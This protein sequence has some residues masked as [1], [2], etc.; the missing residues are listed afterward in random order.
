MKDNQ[1]QSED[2]PEATVSDGP[3]VI[4]TLRSNASR[5]WILTAICLV[6]AVVLFA[7]A[8]RH[9]GTEITVRF[10]QGYGI[11]AGDMLRH[12][13]I[14]VGEVTAVKLDPELGKINVQILL[15]TA[16]EGL[17]RE[18]SRFWVERPR[19]SLARVSGLETVVGA[20]YLGVLPG[21]A[22][23]PKYLFDGDESPLMM[24]DSDVVEITLLFREGYGLQVGDELRHRGIVVG[25]VSAVELNDELSGVEVTVRLIESAQRLARAGSQFWIE[26]PDVSLTRIRGLDTLVGG[27]Y[28]AVAP[29]PSEAE[30]LTKFAGLDEPPMTGEQMEGGLEIALEGRH[31]RGVRAGAPVLY[32]GHRIGQVI[33][34]GLSPDASR[35]E[36]RAYIDPTFKRLVRDNT[37]FW[38]TSGIKANLS[39]SGGL[40]VTA[41]TLETIAAGGVTLATPDSPGKMVNMGHRFPLYN[42]RDEEFDEDTWL[43]WQPHIAVG[44]VDLPEG[45]TMP[46]PI[47]ATLSW[48]E[49]SIIVRTRHRVGWVLP[50]SDGRIVAPLDSLAPPRDAIGGEAKLQLAGEEVAVSVEEVEIHGKLATLPLAKPLEKISPWPVNRLCDPEGIEEVIVTAESAESSFPLPPSKLSAATGVREWS[51]DPSFAID[52]NLNGACVVV[53]K[54][55]CVVGLLVVDKGRAVVAFV[56]TNE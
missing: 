53:P 41:D 51:V 43:Q 35:I 3:A 17:A 11:K 26:R 55:G 14:E 19:L 18:G 9:R 39:I 54:D 47:R 1:T 42:K 2:F 30:Q 36:A 4:Q 12:R 22:A 8:N 13:G 29:G 6:V 44:A 32:R 46:Q 25:E 56:P 38:T 24:L 37:I 52:P 50:L 5:L 23:A 20:K 49:G 27:R 34:V 33:S 48:K 7:A 40:E 15:E 31:R 21:S 45:V 28:I 10:D 16:A